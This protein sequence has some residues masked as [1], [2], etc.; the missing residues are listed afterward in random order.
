MNWSFNWTTSFCHSSDHACMHGS[1]VMLDAVGMRW[2]SIMGNW[3]VREVWCNGCCMMSSRKI[4]HNCISQCMSEILLLLP[5]SWVIGDML[6]TECL[7]I[8][9]QQPKDIC[10]RAGFCSTQNKSVRMEKLMPAKS[11]P[12]VKLFP[13]TKLE[14][15]AKSIPAVKMFPATKL[16]TPVKSK[17]AKV[18]E[19]LDSVVFI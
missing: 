6:L 1:R 12:A 8:P 16:E 14:T 18:Q 7:T 19:H 2:S 3:L 10:S 5:F 17:P 13:A 9:L 15:P 11:I 4:V